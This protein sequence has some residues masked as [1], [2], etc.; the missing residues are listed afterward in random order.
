MK[1]NYKIHTKKQKLSI[2]PLSDIHY[3]STNFDEDFFNYWKYTFQKDKNPKIIYL[4]GDL[5]ESASKKIGNSSYTQKTNLNGQIDWIIN[6]FKP[7]K[8]YI[9]GITWGNHELRLKTEFDLNLTD[10][11]SNFLGIPSYPS[12]YDTFYIN[13]K[14]YIFYGAHGT[15]TSSEN[16]LQL[17]AIIRAFKHVKADLLCMGH[18]HKLLSTS[19]VTLTP[20]GYKRSYYISTGSFLRYVDSYAEDKGLRPIP[21]GFSRIQV[22]LNLKTSVELY[23]HDEVVREDYKLNQLG[24]IDY[25]KTAKATGKTMNEVGEELGYKHPLT[26]L[27]QYLEIRNT[28]WSDL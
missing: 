5:L 22:D 26:A 12:I 6:T 8:K 7:Y 18:S 24:G 28:R 4:L 13:K 1:N 15:K 20:D 23:H 16:H 3:G 27:S 25:L 11:I 14:P 9:R 21:M 10:I 2:Y 19:D 17:G